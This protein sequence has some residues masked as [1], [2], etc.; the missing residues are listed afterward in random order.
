[1][2]GPQGM[3]P[4]IPGGGVPGFPG[5]V[6]DHFT[7]VVLNEGRTLGQTALTRSLY[8]PIIGAGTTPQVSIGTDSQAGFGGPPTTTQGMKVVANVPGMVG[9]TLYEYH[10]DTDKGNG[11]GSNNQ[12]GLD[13]GDLRVTPFGRSNRKVVCGAAGGFCGAPGS[14]AAGGVAGLPGGSG[15]TAA[16]GATG[17]SQVAGGIGAGGGAN[18]DTDGVGFGGDGGSNASAGGGGYHGG[19]G[20]GSYGMAGAGGSSYI[21]GTFATD[22]SLSALQANPYVG[23]LILTAN[24]RD[25]KPSKAQRDAGAEVIFG[26]HEPLGAKLYNLKDGTSTTPTGSTNN[27]GIRQGRRAEASPNDRYW[28]P[29]AASGE[30]AVDIGSLYTAAAPNR[31]AGHSGWMCEFFAMRTSAS[32]ANGVWLEQLDGS[33]SRCIIDH[34]GTNILVQMVTTAGVIR[35][36][37]GFAANLNQWYHILLRLDSANLWGFYIDGV[38][39]TSWAYP[40][41]GV[42]SAE[43]FA[44]LSAGGGV[45]QHKAMGAFAIHTQDR[46]TAGYVATVIAAFSA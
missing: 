36:A 44:F 19:G 3:G 39:K 6:T 27:I 5:G 28:H 2:T 16:G 11:S 25:P 32:A 21:D 31:D 9:G 4:L 20:G 37:I 34:D 35:S 42:L 30:V 17:G 1:M 38:L 7:D 40:A 24:I 33:T 8:L 10:W 18:G 29:A 45:N 13:S 26:F 15:A 12:S 22:P 46:Y 14:N 23:D 41:A 43:K